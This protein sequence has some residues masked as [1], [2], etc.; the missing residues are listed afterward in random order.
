MDKATA[1]ARQVKAQE[2]TA[3]G[4]VD[5]LAQLARIEAKL[6]KLAIGGKQAK[7]AKQNETE[8]E[9]GA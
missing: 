4:V 2:D 3:Q 5:I 8:T 1:I 6:D 7:P 9:A